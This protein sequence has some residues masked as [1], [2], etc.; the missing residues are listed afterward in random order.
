MIK[1]VASKF[2]SGL[3]PSFTEAHVIKTL[4]EIQAQGEVGRIRLSKTLGLGE[5]TTRTLIKHL[6]REKLI[7]V[8]RSGIELSEH[9]KKLVSALRT[10]MS[11]EIEIPSSPLTIGTFNIAVLVKDVGSAV[12]YGLEQR[13]TA[14]MTGAH[15][16]TTLIFSKNKLTMP[17]VSED[18]FRDIPLIRD[19][20]LSKLKPKENDV[21]IIGSAEDKRSAEFG[22]KMAAFELLKSRTSGGDRI[23]N[24]SL[25]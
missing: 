22:A 1:R 9:G 11:K 20:L 24:D 17:G 8:S 7:K 21:I 25:P 23:E 18:V 2:A 4:E 10:E 15:G 13:D 14:I 12:K 3:A 5:G 19:T 16:A 6:K